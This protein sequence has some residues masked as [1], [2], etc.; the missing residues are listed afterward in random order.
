MFNIKKK[1]KKQ[2]VKTAAYARFAGVTVHFYDD[3]YFD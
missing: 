2:F 3:N 1:W